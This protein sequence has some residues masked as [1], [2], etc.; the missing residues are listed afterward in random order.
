[1]EQADQRASTIDYAPRDNQPSIWRCRLRS[2]ALRLLWGAA[3]GVAFVL[4]VRIINSAIG[5]GEPPPFRYVGGRGG[6]GREQ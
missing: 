3:G 2:W 6:S 4:L 1:M 5:S